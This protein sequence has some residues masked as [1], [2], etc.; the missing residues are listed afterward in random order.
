VKAFDRKF[1]A[2]F[3]AGLPATPAVYRIYDVSGLLIYIGKAKNL[4]RRLGQYRNAK[5]RKAHF[6]MRQIVRDAHRIEFDPCASDREASLLEARLIQEHRPRWNTAGAFYFMYP[7]LGIR[8]QDGITSFCYSTTPEAFAD[9]ELHGAYRSRGITGGAFWA[10]MELLSYVG[11]R[12]PRDRKR[13]V[14]KYSH[15]VSFRRLPDEWM[16]KWRAFLRG[17]SREAMELLVLSL[18]E[19]AG[20]RRKGRDIQK[21]LN[22]L[23]LFWS[24]EACSLRKVR[25]TMAYEVYPVPQKERDFLYLNRRFDRAEA[26]AR[27]ASELLKGDLGPKSGSEVTPNDSRNHEAADRRKDGARRKGR[28]DRSAEHGRGA[29]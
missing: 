17:D 15:V 18:V 11:H 22:R 29:L 14:P 10:L 25:E 7:M 16:G 19:N 1:G 4:R 23:R 8:S 3:V 13:T 24:H 12:Q 27:K 28:A 2:E 26:A 21:S 6:K 20:A 5:R 9:F